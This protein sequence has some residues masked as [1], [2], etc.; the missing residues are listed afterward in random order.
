[1]HIETTTCISLTNISILENYAKQLNVPLRSLIMY[2]LMYAAKNEKRKAIAFKRLSYRKR[3]TED[4][5]RRV[6][7]VLYHSEYEFILDVKKLWKMSLA[8]CIEFCIDNILFEFINY[9]MDQLRRKDTDNYL[10]YYQNRSYTLDFYQEKGIHCITCY[11]GPP[12]E[13]LNNTLSLELA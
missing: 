11:W 5:W 10:P 9:Y 7:L 4:S 6:H 1:M 2:L 8:R 12:P 13:L 3:N